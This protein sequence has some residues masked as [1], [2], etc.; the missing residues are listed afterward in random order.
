MATD[1]LTVGAEGAQPKVSADRLREARVYLG[2]NRD[3]V[4]GAMD[5]ERRWVD[6]IENGRQ[7]ITGEELRK[8]SRLYRRP[9]AWL[10]GETTFQPSPEMLRQVENLTEGDREAVLDFAE[11][12]QGA[13]GPG[14]SRRDRG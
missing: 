13:G 11:F 5:R 10:C 2:L 14:W 4:S 3:D 6:D 12:L 9:V 7:A 1:D 8:L